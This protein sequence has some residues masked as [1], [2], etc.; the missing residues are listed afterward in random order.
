MG[1]QPAAR[2]KPPLWLALGRVS[3]LPTV[4][5]NALAGTVLAGADPWQPATL[6]VCAAL[7]LFYVGGMYLNDAFDAAW[8]QRE[9]PERPIPSGRVRLETVYAAGFGLL[10]AG[11]LCLLVALALR[12][13]GA[14]LIALVAGIALA[15]T[16]LIYDWHHKENPLSPL[17][18]GLCR[19]LAYATAGL[20]ATA[21][22]A[23]HL[24]LLAG[25]SLCWLIGLTYAAK[26]E[27]FDRLERI[28]PLAFL[29]VPLLWGLVQL[30]TGYLTWA[31]LLG[32]AAW[33]AFA[34][35]LL[36]RRAKGDVPRAVAALVAGIALLDALFL[37]TLGHTGASAAAVACFLLTR[38]GQRWIAGS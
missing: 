7:S 2:M 18:M 20:V 29:F 25:A 19:V 28:W 35:F 6:V 13:E 34:L 27:A 15:A 9:R 14:G 11:L 31:L 3:N 16:I 1:A 33:L 8:D 4:W 32:L 23:V 26:Q 24:W 21:Q 22:P 37:A 5:S 36:A 10:L 12:P 38:L 30:A 17:V